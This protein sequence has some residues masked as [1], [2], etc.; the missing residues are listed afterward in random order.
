METPRSSDRHFSNLPDADKMLTAK[1][2]MD[3]L[4][5]EPEIAEPMAL[6]G[7]TADGLL[8]VGRA[9]L[10]A[11]RDSVDEQTERVGDRLEATSDQTDALGSVQALYTYLAESA[12][13]VYRKDEAALTALGLTGEH[14]N[15]YAARIARMRAFV[16][17]ARK[18]ERGSALKGAEVTAGALDALEVS[19]DAAEVRLSMQ[20]RHTGRSKGATAV[21]QAAFAGLTDWMLSMHGHARAKLQGRE[22]LL[23]VLGA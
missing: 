19:V 21:R 2:A 13:T 1:T 11:V 7:Y 10:Q 22:E 9:L 6:R 18:E 16:V 5:G 14:E 23:D 12:R 8:T 3:A 20:D 4:E 15:S 17:E